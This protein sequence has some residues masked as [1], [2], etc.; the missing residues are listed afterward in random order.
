ML[1][2]DII[3]QHPRRGGIFGGIFFLCFFGPAL[4]PSDSPSNSMH[5]ALFDASVARFWRFLH[6]LLDFAIFWS[7]NTVWCPHSTP[8]WCPHSTLCGIHTTHCVVST[9]HTVWCPHSTLC[10]VHTVWC[11]HDGDFVL[12]YVCFCVFLL[13]SAIFTK[14]C[15]W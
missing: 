4:V 7:Q 15:V 9:Q 12:I 3:K 6:D 5:F 8:V 10:G 2:M 13:M 11:P 1:V 14:R